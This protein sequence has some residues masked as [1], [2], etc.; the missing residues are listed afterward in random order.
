METHLVLVAKSRCLV[1]SHS[2][3][4]WLSKLE[5]HC[6]AMLDVVV[7]VA[8]DNPGPRVVERCSEDDISICW[9]LYDIFENRTVK[10]SWQT[11]T[12]VGTIFVH[13]DNEFSADFDVLVKLI[14]SDDVVP[15]SMLMYRVSYTSIGVGVY[16]N[17]FKPF[18]DCLW[19]LENMTA[20][21][22][23][24]LPLIC[25]HCHVTDSSTAASL[26]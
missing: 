9:N 15:A 7:D 16:Q 3:A 18:A 17:Y 10:V 21:C 11:H 1:W 13:L 8:V 12:S 2:P 20:V 25:T 26:V 23:L 5:D 4:V 24:H 6:H 14:L 19:L 22:K